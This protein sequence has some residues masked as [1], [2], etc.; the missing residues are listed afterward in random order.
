MLKALC[1]KIA[2]EGGDEAQITIANTIKHYVQSMNA[3]TL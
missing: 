2:G 3:S 1:F